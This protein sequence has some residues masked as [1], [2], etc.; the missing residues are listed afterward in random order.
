ME[1]EDTPNPQKV[2]LD[3][4]YSGKIRIEILEV[5][6]GDKYEDTCITSLIGCVDTNMM[7]GG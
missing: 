2:S 1:L 4:M 7:M 5:Y 6:P 3:V